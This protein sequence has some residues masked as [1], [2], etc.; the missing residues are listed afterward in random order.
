LRL[1]AFGLLLTQTLLLANLSL[2][3]LL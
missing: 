3:M 1:L 2:E